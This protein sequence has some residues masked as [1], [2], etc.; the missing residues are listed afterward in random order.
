[1]TTN[2]IREKFMWSQM[3]FSTWDKQSKRWNFALNQPAYVFFFPK[4]KAFL[5]IA[6]GIGK[7]KD[8]K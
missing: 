2:Y 5:N 4:Q 7:K 6:V 3:N 8:K 1:M